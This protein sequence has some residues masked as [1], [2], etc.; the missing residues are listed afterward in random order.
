MPDL[1]QEVRQIHP[2]DALMH[3]ARGMR[4]FEKSHEL[5]RNLLARLVVALDEEV[6]SGERPGGDR[7]S[8]V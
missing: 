7:K 2:L 5:P 8:V 1:L 6:E 3:H 4:I